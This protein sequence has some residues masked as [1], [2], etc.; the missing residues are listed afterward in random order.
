[1]FESHY[2]QN[3]GLFFRL[4][5]LQLKQT[6]MQKNFYSLVALIAF[7]LSGFAQ[8]SI[9]ESNQAGIRLDAR[10]IV[11]RQHSAESNHHGHSHSEEFPEKCI[12]HSQTEA[13]MERDEE[14]RT[15]VENYLEQ[16]RAIVTELESGE[17][18]APPV[19]TIPV[20]FHVIHKGEAVGSGTNISTAQLESAIDALNRDYR[21]TSEDGGIAQGAGPDTEIQFCLAGVDPNGNP[22]SGINRVNGTSVSGYSSNGLTTGFSGNEE[23]VKDLSRWDHRYYMNVW[24]V[25]EI[26]NNGAD[27]NVNSFFGGTLGF[28]YLPSTF[29][30]NLV[31]G[32]LDGIVILN[33]AVG[34]DPNGTNG[35]RL[36]SA[37][38]TNRTLTHEAGHFLGL[39][40]PFSDNNPNSCT[41]GD[42]IGDTPNA[43][44][45]SA[46]S[47]NP[48]G[49]CSGQMVENYMDYMPE[50]CQDQFT[51]GQTNVMRGTLA[52]ARNE[53][54]NTSN[55]GVST[56]Y[57]ASISA[58]IQPSGS[59]CNTT[60]TPE[61]T[62]YNYGSTTLTSVQIQ[63]F[64]DSQSPSTFSWSGSLGSNSSTTVTLPSVSTTAGS[65]T[66]TA[67]TVSNTLNGSQN[68]QETSNDQTVTNFSVG[69]GSALT[70]TLNLDCWG[71]ETTWE[72]VN[73][74]NATVASGGP[75]T[76]NLPGGAG[77]ITEQ[78]CLAQ[79]CYDFILNDSNNDGINGGTAFSS[80]N[81]DGSYTI[82]DGNNSTLVQL[83]ASEGGFGASDT[84]NFCVGNTN[85]PVQTCDVLASY[86]GE[87][88]DVNPADAANFE[89]FITDVDQADVFTGLANAGLNS[90]WMVDFF[91]TSTT[92]GD[93]NW[94]AGSTSYH[95]D[96]T[97]AADNWMTFGPIT[98]LD[99]DGELRWK[100]R[101]PDND[102]RD[103]Y[104]VLVGTA[105]VTAADFSGATVLYS[106]NDNDPA[107]NGDTVWVQNAVPLP[108]GTYANQSLY[109]AIHHNALDMFL[110]FIDDIEVEG[111]T[112]LTVGV[113]EAENLEFNV[114]PNPS[115]ENFTFTYK[116]ETTSEM[117]FE[118]VNAMGQIVWRDNSNNSTQGTR[119]IE[120]RELSSGVYTL[121][122][123]S[124]KF[125]ASKRLVLSK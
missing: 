117:R 20:V 118:L 64:V 58:I 120:T 36:W 103:G 85:P 105:G 32:D 122:A 75:Y 43:R 9:L 101:M 17:R 57:D 45:V 1:M 69:S 115:N 53:L 92:P 97:I 33:L 107:T 51:N 121:I 2:Q 23:S 91:Y 25:S 11:N 83:P 28:A 55:C 5:V 109:F 95:N 48:S 26:D 18:A 93:T 6:I 111:C 56:D 34:N 40:H 66:F 68:D 110:L 10:S 3:S 41:D 67:R 4:F 112:Q 113:E 60:F 50:Q 98:M 65:H 47:C 52:G 90:N 63:Y 125:N 31:N 86:D 80:C 100:H 16:T 61:V 8:T 24:V 30:G 19:Y 35:Y 13:L 96:N 22:H 72:I 104:E 124:D 88:F 71:S 46:F 79:G 15:G 94:Y 62:L 49:L 54:V 7:T 84:R 14:Y 38:L 12:Q 82:V 119:F 108:S 78:L 74:S 70:L 116:T 42:G 59:L 77:T 99:G 114:F 27:G 123:R 87:I 81:V 106:V 76:D 73:S 89:A 37:G 29:G 44:Q 102:Y 21:R 39:A